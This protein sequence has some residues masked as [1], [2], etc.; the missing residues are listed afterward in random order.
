MPRFSAGQSVANQIRQRHLGVMSGGAQ[1]RASTFHKGVGINQNKGGMNTRGSMPGLR[2]AKPPTVKLQGPA[3]PY[4]GPALTPQPRPAKHTDSGRL[5]MPGSKPGFVKPQGGYRYVDRNGKKTAVAWGKLTDAERGQFSNGPK[6]TAPAPAA[7]E[8]PGPAGPQGPLDYTGLSA[9]KDG[10]SELDYDLAG[11]RASLTRQ[12]ADNKIAYQRETGDA[13]RGYE[14]DVEAGEDSLSR[15]N[16][17]RSGVREVQDADRF[18]DFDRYMAD[19]E[20]QYG[21]GAL[22]KINEALAGLDRFEAEAR[23]RIEEGARDEYGNM[24]PAA[25]IEEMPEVNEGAA[26]GGA[27][28]AATATARPGRPAWQR[29]STN[30]INRWATKLNGKP[31]P[32]VAA[33]GKDYRYVTRGGK[34]VAV[35]ASKL[36]AA[37]RR[38]FGL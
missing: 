13:K 21:S 25:P 9:Y 26:A 4:T 5:P 17:L 22:A 18:R 36:T 14:R 3:K 8:T 33:G 35:L 11:Q 19:V 1:G 31:A 6:L 24:Y 20:S 10:M 28:T 15:G 29:P 32:P 2:P 38:Q 12:I 16:L 37:E 30:A 34:R 27:T 23:R 7:P